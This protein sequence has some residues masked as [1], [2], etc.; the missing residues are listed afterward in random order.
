MSFKNKRRWR[1]IG[2]YCIGWTLAFLFLVIVRGVGT[3]ENGRVD[4]GVIPGVLFAFVI[5]PI[6]GSVS[7]YAQILTDEKF[8]RR[9]SARKLFFIRLL[10]SIVFLLILVSAAYAFFPSFSGI[11]ISFREFIL[12]KG[13]APIYFYIFC[14]DIFM[15]ALSQVNLM[16]GGNNLWKIL[17]GKFYTPHE[18]DRVFMFL[19]L[20][21][22]T[23][24]AETLGHIKYSKFIQDCFNDLGVVIEDE[25][26]IYQYVGD[27]VILTWKLK[28]GLRN[29]NCIHAFFRFKNQLLKREAYYKKTYD[30]VPFFKAGVNDGVVTA[31]EVGKYKKEIAYHGDTINTAARIQGKCN[32]FNQELLISESLKNKLNIKKYHCDLIGNIALRGKNT[33]VQIYSV[34]Q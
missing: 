34:S 17:Q 4:I 33:D 5:G 28:D 1:I 32:E 8:Y 14:V 26:E 3:T 22:S 30:R 19:D 29:E 2:I 25:A 21:S 18:E 7:G 6:L 9:T 31:T 13:S 15:A 23:Q 10:I 11:D 16:F 12:D 20:Q 27:E 24:H